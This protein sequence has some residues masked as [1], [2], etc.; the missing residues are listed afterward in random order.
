MSGGIV[1]VSNRLPMTVTRREG[2]GFDVR[3]STGGLAS[4]LRGIHERMGGSWVGWPGASF[5]DNEWA[6][7]EGEL[8]ASGARPVPLTPTEVGE[9]YQGV[10]NGLL[11]PLLH[12]QIDRL[13]MAAGNWE[14]FERVNQR[15]AAA[16]VEAYRP[17][18]LIWI[19]DYHLFLLPRLVRERLPD[20]RIGFFLHVPFPSSE[21]FSLLPWRREIIQGM[22]GADLIGF[23]TAGYLRHF[24]A[25]LRRIAGLDV[26]VDSVVVDGRR[27]RLGAFP[28]GVDA[29]SLSC[30]AANTSVIEA[31]LHFREQ[32]PSEKWLVSV[33]RLD[34]T[35][36]IPRR[37][38]AIDTLLTDNPGLRERVRLVQ[39]T[40]PSREET[41]DY[42]RLHTQVDELVGRVN[43]RW[44][45]PNWSPI[46]HIH[47]ALP[48]EDLLSLYLA[49]DAMVVTPLRDGMNLVAKEFIAARNDGDGVL[50]LSEFAGAAAELPGAVIVNPYNIPA[51]A[52]AI[53]RALEMPAPERKKRMAGMRETVFT[54]TA[55]RWAAH[56]IDLL[57]TTSIHSER[58][59]G[60]S[61]ERPPLPPPDR[62][63]NILLDYDGTLVPFAATPEVAIPDEPLLELL[64]NLTA[65]GATVQIVSGRPVHFLDSHFGE[66]LVGLHA[67]HGLWMRTPASTAW[68][69]RS[70]PGVSW[71]EAVQRHLEQ[72]VSSTPGSLLEQKDA[73]FSWHFRLADQEFGDDTDYGESQA[74]ELRLLLN[75]VLGNQRAQ[76]LL[77][78]RVIEVRPSSVNKGLVVQGLSFGPSESIIAIG[79]DTTDEDLF[80]ALP[81]WAITIKVGPGATTARYRLDS[82]DEVRQYLRRVAGNMTATCARSP[83]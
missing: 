28:L 43:S 22:L 34:Y 75:E 56:F 74:R 37:I 51:T 67:E 9:Y 71:R 73:S 32:A 38:L 60:P 59:A 76:V 39:V 7:L 81:D 26:D 35:K 27:V 46:H 53:E 3:P 70:I 52:R 82:V 18:D 20:A 36:G 77:G 21:V 78:N 68:T 23:H 14:T 62:R 55:Q 15:F 6:A 80:R 11:W 40:A 65:S 48:A 57:T 30:S 44:A 63:A 79:D 69:R 29:D 50:V 72:F 61:E 8:E 49:A 58:T 17:G 5:D 33:D 24:C 66:L 10:A 31:A 2:D 64:A 1:L 12:Y 83:A 13:P 19:H 41:A 25:T 45:T 16:V 42:S 4:G 47:R 54:N